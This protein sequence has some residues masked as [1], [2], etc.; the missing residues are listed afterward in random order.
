MSKESKEIREVQQVSYNEKTAKGMLAFLQ[1]LGVFVPH[2]TQPSVVLAN[3]TNN[4]EFDGCAVLLFKDEQ[5]LI[6]WTIDQNAENAHWIQLVR[7]GILTVL[8]TVRILSA[9]EAS[10]E[11]AEAEELN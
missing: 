4:A 9:A 3:A 2:D 11:A 10:A 6:A 8:D 5:T 1:A 7:S